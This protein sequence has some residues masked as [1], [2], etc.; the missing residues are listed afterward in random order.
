M[1]KIIN[2]KI[3]I[4]AI[5]VILLILIF[6]LEFQN[7]KQEYEVGLIKKLVLENFTSELYPEL[8][9]VISKNISFEKIEI[10]ENQA[11]VEIFSQWSPYHCIGYKY[12]LMKESGKWVIISKD[13]TGICSGPY[14]PAGP[15]PY[16]R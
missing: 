10:K 14:R 9:E 6:G 5:L 1:R 16:E 8:K 7:Y 13:M 2:S 3:K 15:L 4:I 11:T 12:I